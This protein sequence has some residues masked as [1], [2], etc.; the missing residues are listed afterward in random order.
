MSQDRQEK[1]VDDVMNLIGRLP[2]VLLRGQGGVRVGGRSISVDQPPTEEPAPADPVG[3]FL[4][5][6]PKF[7]TKES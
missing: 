2:P 3:E 4:R 5:K 6:D 7:R 1:K